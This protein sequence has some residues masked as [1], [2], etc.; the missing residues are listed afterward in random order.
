MLEPLQTFSV[1]YLTR[2]DVALM[3]NDCIKENNLDIGIFQIFDEDL[4]AD[5]CQELANEWGTLYNKY[6]ARNDMNTYQHLTVLKVL[7][8]HFS[9]DE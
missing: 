3:F 9:K 8:K 1:L 5:I 7:M 6:P 2:K 4:T